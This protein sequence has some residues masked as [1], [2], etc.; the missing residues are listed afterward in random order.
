[1]H[2]ESDR[3]AQRQVTRFLTRHRRMQIVSSGQ[4]FTRRAGMR[5]L[6]VQVDRCLQYR[7]AKGV[8]LSGSLNECSL[9]MRCSYSG[10]ASRATSYVSRISHHGVYF[11]ACRRGTSGC[12]E[13]SDCAQPCGVKSPRAIA[14]YPGI[15]CY[16]CGGECRKYCLAFIIGM[17]FIQCSVLSVL[18]NLIH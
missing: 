15:R 8:S 1:M 4:P 9:P 11:H 7:I 17:L 6:E 14:D 10:Y 5:F 3:N 13:E 16:D 2:S 12:E 18:F